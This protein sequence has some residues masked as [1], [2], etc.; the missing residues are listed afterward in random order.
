MDELTLGSS[1]SKS[2]A[3]EPPLNLHTVHGSAG[4]R[5]GVRVENGKVAQLLRIEELSNPILQAALG[6]SLRLKR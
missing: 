2:M 6:A 1:A 4:P 3:V 5:D